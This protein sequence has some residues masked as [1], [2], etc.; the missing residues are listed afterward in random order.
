MA[1]A[2]RSRRP[3]ALGKDVDTVRMEHVW[4]ASDVREPAFC[5]TRQLVPPSSL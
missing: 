4:L 2:R 1:G 5:S 3:P